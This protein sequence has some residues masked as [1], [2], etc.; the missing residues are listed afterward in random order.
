MVRTVEARFGRRSAERVLEQLENAFEW[1]ASSPGIGHRRDDLTV[2]ERVRFWP[3]G[4]SL[5]AYRSME[6]RVEI[7]IVER[8]ELDWKRLLEHRLR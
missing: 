3:V 5:V 6:K 8:G 2:D 7:L 1:L 4:A